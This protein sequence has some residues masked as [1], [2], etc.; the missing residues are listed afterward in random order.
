MQAHECLSGVASVMDRHQLS[1]TYLVDPGKNVYRRGVICL[2]VKWVSI[3]TGL[4][5]LVWGSINDE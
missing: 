1:N 3:D 4:W 2:Q 5:M